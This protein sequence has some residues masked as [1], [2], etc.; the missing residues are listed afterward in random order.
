MYPENQVSVTGEKEYLKI[1]E[2]HKVPVR[3]SPRC[4]SC[5]TW[6]AG[7]V[8]TLDSRTGVV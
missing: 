3:P 5:V 6:V 7:G 2:Y 4:G 1:N 8:Q